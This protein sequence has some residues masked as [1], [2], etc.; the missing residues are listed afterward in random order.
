MGCMFTCV[1]SKQPF[2][3]SCP[4]VHVPNAIKRSLLHFGIFCRVWK[5]YFTIIYLDRVC[6][7]VAVDEDRQGLQPRLNRLQSSRIVGKS[8]GQTDVGKQQH[9][10]ID[11]IWL[12]LTK[13][14]GMMKI[15]IIISPFLRG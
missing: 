11:N 5:Y 1:E 13:L 14:V 9:L 8:V 2:Q 10:K 3:T 7:L 15:Y 6:Q 4:S 12:K